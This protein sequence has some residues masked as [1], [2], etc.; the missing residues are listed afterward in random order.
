[1]VY[2]P[3]ALLAAQ[4]AIWV[5]DHSSGQA[6]AAFLSAQVTA[7]P[8]GIDP[9]RFAE[10]CRLVVRQTEMLRLRLTGLST[11]IVAAA[12]ANDI[13]IPLVDLTAEHDPDEAAERWMTAARHARIDP[14]TSPAFAWALLAVAPD[15]LLWSQIY[16]HAVSDWHGRQ[17]VVARVAAIYDA[18]SQGLPP[19]EPMASPRLADMAA[20]ETAYFDSPRY[21]DD[22]AWCVGQCRDRPASMSLSGRSTVLTQFGRR[23]NRGV[24]PMRTQA[25]QDAAARLNVSL[26]QLL[27]AAWAALLGRLSG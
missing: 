22:G 5:A 19:P 8:P 3:L 21:H 15:R 6:T 13:Q 4:Q 11:Q 7:L 14:M 9:S 27:C 10:A 18:L 16:H 12:N 23:A 2:E 20:E 26:A 1:V 17:L 24:D 25:L